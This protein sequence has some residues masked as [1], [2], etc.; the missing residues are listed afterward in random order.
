MMLELGQK[1]ILPIEDIRQIPHVVRIGLGDRD[2]M[3][4]IEESAEVFRSLPR[5]ELQ[6]FPNTPHLLEKV[7][8]SDLA[9][10]ITEFF[11]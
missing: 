5:G 2:N 9:H 4:S 7:P 3:V 11:V 1:N 6:I 8:L 10:S